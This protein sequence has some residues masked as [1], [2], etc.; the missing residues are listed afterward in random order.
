VGAGYFDAPAQLLDFRTPTEGR[1][2]WDLRVAAQDLDGNK[3]LKRAAGRVAENFVVPGTT[4]QA[5]ITAMT[6]LAATGASAFAAWSANPTTDLTGYLIGEGMP[7]GA[8]ATASQNIM[9][10]FNAAV[11]AVRNPG[12]GIAESSLRQGLGNGNWIAVSGEDDSPDFPVNVSIAPYPQY[13]LDLTIPTPQGPGNSVNV[14]IRYIVASS[15]SV[16][17]GPCS[18]TFQGQWPPQPYIPPGDEVILFIHGEASRAEEACDLIPALFSVAQAANRSVTVIAF[19]MPGSAYSTM[20]PHLSVAPWPPAAVILGKVETSG[21]AGS[22]IL[23]FVQRTIEAFVEAL[24]LPGGNPITAIVGGSLGGHMALRLASSQNAWVTNVV[25][26][27]PASVEDH[28]FSLGGIQISQR[29]LTDPQLTSRASDAE[30]QGS[31]AAF[32]SAVWDQNTFDP[33]Q[34]WF[35]IGTIAIA[36]V[37]AGFVFSV[38]GIFGVFFL[39]WLAAALLALPTVPPQPTMWYRDSWGPAVAGSPF[40]AAKQAYMFEGR[41]D[42]REIYCQTSR[43]WH[44]RICEELLGFTFDPQNVTKRLLLMVGELD[45]YPEAHF[46]DNVKAFAGQLSGPGEALTVQNTGH[47]IH[48]ERPFFLANQILTFAPPPAGLGNDRDTWLFAEIL[49]S[50]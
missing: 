50:L 8:A 29:V 46:L 34:P 23:D 16:A 14:N 49:P 20:V 30:V 19:D 39:G 22:P 21:F 25:A 36:L 35:D 37:S 38:G 28:N 6:Q 31:R 42:R 45:N 10:D 5:V 7:A 15:Q 3:I 1:L 26:W 32:F 48:N 41:L 24:I 17:G 4:S 12:A 40:G 33:G 2:L 18:M 11:Q 9:S 47:S 27:S 43:Q 13:H 44:W